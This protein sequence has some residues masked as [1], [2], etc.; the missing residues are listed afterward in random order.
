MIEQRFYK[1]DPYC[2]VVVKELGT[3]TC[4]TTD[5]EALSTNSSGVSLIELLSVIGI[6]LMLILVIAL[7]FILVCCCCTKKKEKSKSVDIG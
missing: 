1:V 4:D 5:Q 3:T 7:I 6:G 2:S